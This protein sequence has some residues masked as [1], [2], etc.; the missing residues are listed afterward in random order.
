MLLGDRLKV[1]YAQRHVITGY[2]FVAPALAFLLLFGVFPIVFAFGIS[3]H[4]WNMVDSRKRNAVCR[5]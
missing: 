5:G 4:N 3:L 2:L 1:R